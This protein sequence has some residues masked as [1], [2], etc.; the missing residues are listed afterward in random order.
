MHQWRVEASPRPTT[1]A[2]N[3]ETLVAE[4]LAAAPPAHMAVDDN[5]PDGTGQLLDRLTRAHDGRLIELHR[6]RKLGPDTAH[7]LALTFG[8]AH[9]YSDA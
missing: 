5:S 1:E 4:C 2:D 3:I 8:L 7:E 9:G 6:P